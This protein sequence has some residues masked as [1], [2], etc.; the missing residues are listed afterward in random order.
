MEDVTNK[1]EI[2]EREEA[3]LEAAAFFRGCNSLTVAQI[4]EEFANRVS[5]GLDMVP[6]DD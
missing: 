3:L 4:L 5:E 6:S 1:N 2:S